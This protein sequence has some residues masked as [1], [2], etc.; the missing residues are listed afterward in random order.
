MAWY[1][2]ITMAHAEAFFHPHRRR[3]KIMAV[4]VA[5]IAAIAVLIIGGFVL[6][7]ADG[8]QRAQVVRGHMDGVQQ[9]L[10]RRDV[11]AASES[12]TAAEE[13]LASMA[14]RVQMFRVL[15]PFPYVGNQA[16]SLVV[17]VEDG[18][19]TLS[20][21]QN[22]LGIAIDIENDLRA[23]GLIESLA[24]VE[25]FVELSPEA[26][27]EL[28]YALNRAVPDLEEAQARM[29][30]RRAALE[31]MDPGQLFFAL[32]A[33]RREML[34]QVQLLDDSL[35]LLIPVLSVLPSV[36]GFEGPQHHLVFLQNDGELRP[37]GGFWGTYAVIR[38]ENGEIAD[39]V[40]DDIY[41]VDFPSEGLIVRTPPEP[42]RRY[43]GVDR[44][45]LR[46]A[47][48]SPDVPT[49]LAYGLQLYRD[50]TQLP[51][52]RPVTAPKVNMVGSAL[53][54]SAVGEQLLSI[55]GDVTVDGVTF[56]SDNLYDE[57][58][59]QVEQAFVQRR[60]ET[61]DRKDVIGDLINVLLE[62]LHA[63]DPATL[64]QLLSV[65]RDLLANNDIMLYSTNGDVQR[66]FER[67]RWAGDL[68]LSAAHDHLMIVDANLAALKT[69]KAIS[70]A[71]TYSI[72]KDVDGDLMATAQINYDHRGGF[73]YRT[74]RYRTYTRVYVP[75]G[76]ELVKV[77][78]ALKNDRTK[79][80]NGEVGEADAYEEF[81]ATVFGAFTS[82][83][84]GES[85]RLSFT[86][87][88]PERIRAAYE[89]G[90][91]M[92]DV[93]R[94]PGVGDVALNLD[95]DF[96][97][98]IESAEPSEVSEYWFDDS[99]THTTQARPHQSFR[100]EF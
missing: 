31:T 61:L 62:R 45:Y 10:A 94:Q 73:D 38:V 98:P 70:R 84:P 20:V 85:G 96:D 49:S 21:L 46:D 30:Q 4:M 54:T 74:T 52:D 33:V 24:D 80:P 32:R 41:T 87:K 89:A 43:L 69:D 63:A 92:L 56:T 19:A 68:R 71:Y 47:N 40:T 6:L 26:R 36:G 67:E 81:G 2:V 48:W 5:F 77:D 25:G 79:N 13:V 91:Y 58:E 29:S 51:P 93:Q 97:T 57:L 44:W 65:T 99:Y 100:M 76:S 53:V 64:S 59:Y 86:Y 34:E 11:Q 14:E 60:I 9:A 7:V 82:V 16:A 37:T 35:T 28:V 88:L 83:E 8:L 17:L 55:L 72:Y 42:L 78:G 1:H 95:L 23:V 90:E 18:Q 15:Q 22:L 27:R 12:L 50:E 3:R 66:I 39:I 75:K